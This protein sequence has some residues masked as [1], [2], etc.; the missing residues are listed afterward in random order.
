MEAYSFDDPQAWIKAVVMGFHGLNDPRG[1]IKTILP[2]LVRS[3]L[4]RQFATGMADD[5]EL[6]EL[7]NLVDKAQPMLI[8]FFTAVNFLLFGSQGHPLA[9]FHPYLTE[10]PRPAQDAYPDFRDFCLS[11]RSE[12]RQMLPQARLQT[13]EVTRCANLLP[14]FHLVAKRGGNKPLALI[15]IGTSAG[16]NLNWFRY[17]YVYQHILAVGHQDS[18]VQIHCG[19]QGDHTPD[20]PAFL[21]AVARCIGIDLQPLH[22]N[23]EADVRWL[24]AHI[25]PHENWRYALLDAAIHLARQHLPPLLPG[26]ARHLLPELLAQ[27]PL[28][29]TVCVFHSF[30][31]NQGSEA[32]RQQIEQQLAHASRT[33]IVFQVALEIDL[34]ATGLPTLELRTYRA[35]ELIHHERLAYC[36]LHGEHLTWLKSA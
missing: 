26:D 5:S 2:T 34:G 1:W 29:Q 13:N 24:R 8:L 27:T 17:G 33:R 11:H 3:P 28:E 12:L 30:A 10:R 31:L 19:L 15:E 14:A 18:P 21:P 36:T 4:Y 20:F 7:L 23:N 22:L 32:V 35:G 9:E 16:L 25:W 6:I